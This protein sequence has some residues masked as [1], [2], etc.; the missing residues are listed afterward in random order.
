MNQ[1]LATI[2]KNRKG[3]DLQ[4]LRPGFVCRPAEPGI[5]RVEASE[6]PGRAVAIAMEHLAEGRFVGIVCPP[7]RRP[8]LVEA[9]AANQVEWSGADQGDLGTAINVVGPHEAKGL[10][11]DA[12]VVVEPEDIVSGDVRGH[13]MLF[14]ALTRTTRYLDIVAAG[15]PLPMTA[16]PARVPEQRPES[17][18]APDE[19]GI[20]GLAEQIAAMVAG[21]APAPV[22]YEVLNRAAALLD[23]QAESAPK[24][25]VSGRHRRG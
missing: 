18:F 2:G 11:F 5:H 10:E 4:H 8:E 6:R 9:L 17:L 13:R 24:R 7:A 15:D 3:G 19:R 14:I 1:F 22:W 20:D 16:T 25:T 21:G 12:V 23:R